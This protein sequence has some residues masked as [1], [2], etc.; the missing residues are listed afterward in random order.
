MAHHALPQGHEGGRLGEA[1]AEADGE[2]SG[3]AGATHRRDS[4]AVA[5]GTDER[6]TGRDE[7]PVPGGSVTRP[8][9]PERG[10]LHRHD[11]PDWQPGGP[12]VRSGQIHVK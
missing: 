11:L 2:G 3:D 5:L 7:R 10:Q 1:T 6:T 4:Q 9:L 12:L 8:R